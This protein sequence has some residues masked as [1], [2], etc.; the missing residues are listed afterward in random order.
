M[1]YNSKKLIDE[2]VL[3]QFYFEKFMLSNSNER[4]Q[5]LPSKFFEYSPTNIIKGLNPEVKVGEVSNGSSHIT[6][7]VL[8]P[9]IA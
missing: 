6:D 7:F 3:Q 4:K 8:H 1:F 5:L 9:F 2:K